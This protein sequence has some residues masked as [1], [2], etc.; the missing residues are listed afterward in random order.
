MEGALLPERRDNHASTNKK[1]TI[2][3]FQ[4]IYIYHNI[5]LQYLL[6]MSTLLKYKISSLLFDIIHIYSIPFK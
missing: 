5:Y 4:L 2:V 6:L 1:F 3:F